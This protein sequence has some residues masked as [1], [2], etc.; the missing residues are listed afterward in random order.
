MECH[1]PAEIAALVQDRSERQI[2]RD[3]DKLK[4]KEKEAL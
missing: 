4:R 1:T 3:V 2:R